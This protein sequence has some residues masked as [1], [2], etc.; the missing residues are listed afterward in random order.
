MGEYG[1]R[2]LDVVAIDVD[3]VR[4]QMEVR[5]TYGPYPPVGLRAKTLLFVLGR[6]R[7]DHLLAVHICGL[8]G[9]GRELGLLPS[10]LLDL[11]DLLSL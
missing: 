5:G 3:V 6:R 10:L 8:G 9:H 2:I 1:R 7:D 11:G 4:P